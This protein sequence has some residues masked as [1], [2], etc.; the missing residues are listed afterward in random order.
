MSTDPSGWATRCAAH[1]LDRMR[2]ADP[3]HD[4]SH[5]RRVVATATRLAQEEQADALIVIPASWLHDL[6]DIPKDDPRRGLAS[7]LSAAAGVE[8][9]RAEGY[10]PDR[11]AA[12]RHAIEAHSFSARIEPRTIEA[13]VVQDADR[14]EALGAIGIARCFA[15]GGT[16]GRR[17]YDEADPFGADW[18]DPTIPPRRNPDDGATTLDHFWAKL[19]H[20]AATLR[21]AA[22]RQEGLRRTRTMKSFL[23]EFRREIGA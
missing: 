9:L 11:L 1:A 8:F 12:V 16:M 17:F 13:E 7:T 15:T 18:T 20:V 19:F 5:V 10:P 3:A 6:V 22:G 14:L 21:T 23:S 4:I 2:G